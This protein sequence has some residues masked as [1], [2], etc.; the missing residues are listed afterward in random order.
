MCKSKSLGGLGL[1]DLKEFNQ[2]LLAKW[3]RKWVKNERN[4]WNEVNWTLHMTKREWNNGSSMKFWRDIAEIAPTFEN[5]TLHLVRS[6]R[7]ISF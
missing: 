7:N 1:I 2:A 5:R 6:G 3:M 4:L